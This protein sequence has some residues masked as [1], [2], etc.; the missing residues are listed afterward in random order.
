MSSAH[1]G[2]DSGVTRAVGEGGTGDVGADD[3]TAGV[4]MLVDTF[5]DHPDR[6]M[7]ATV[8][9]V[10]ELLSRAA[11]VLTRPSG[12]DVHL[13]HSSGD[14]VRELLELQLELGRGPSI[15]A[16]RDGQPSL[17]TSE[18]LWN[19]L[20]PHLSR[21]AVEAGLSFLA[22][23]P[24][25]SRGRVVGSLTIIWFDGQKP[26][27]D[28]IQVAQT[29]AD[30]AA[31]GIVTQGTVQ[32]AQALTTQLQQ[33]LD[34]RVVIEQAKGV[35]LGVGCP[36]LP[37]AFTT[38]RRHARDNNLVIGEAAQQVVDDPGLAVSILR[39]PTVPAPRRRPPGSR[40]S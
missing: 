30:T 13:A 27:K 17:L 25:R 2:A 9:T 18:R 32:A 28:E 40:S 1:D 10:A 38:L 24:L 16:L 6:L 12:Q 20:H 19:R 3:V 29:I 21:A 36:S 35:L 14:S 37:E 4:S 39:R 31:V 5:L 33:A 26:T 23:L 11:G 34:S 22:S 8:T 15:D 7:S